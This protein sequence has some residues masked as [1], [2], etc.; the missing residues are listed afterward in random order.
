LN[1]RQAEG[2]ARLLPLL[3][4]GEEAA[5]LAFDGLARSHAEDPIASDALQTIASEELIHDALIRSMS[6]RL[7]PPRGVTEMLA[8]ARRFH[9]NLGRG[10]AADHLAR[11]TALDSAVC[12]ILARLIRPSAPLAAEA[13]IAAILHRISRDE[14]RHVR[15]SRR[16]ARDRRDAR[17]LREIAGPTRAALAQL[18]TLASADFDALAVDPDRLCRDLSRLPDGLFEE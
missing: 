6:D 14:A 3:G 16:L 2:L 13:S 7:P 12:T 15:V 11:I 10:G 5:S 8:A 17:V 18:L 1:G 4:C 9:V